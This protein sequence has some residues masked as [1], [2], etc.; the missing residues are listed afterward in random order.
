M[1]EKDPDL[2]DHTIGLS[3]LQW[4]YA[5]MLRIE[6][7]WTDQVQNQQRRIAAVLAVNGFLLAF[8]ATAGLQ[9][10]SDHLRGWYYYPF[11]LC[12]LLLSFALVFGV[13]TLFPQIPIAGREHGSDG[14][15]QRWIRDTF[16]KAAP[17]DIDALWLNAPAVWEGIS[18]EPSDA[19]FASTLE[20][21][22]KSLSRSMGNQSHTRAMTRRRKWMN[23]QIFFIVLSLVLLMVAVVGQAVH[24]L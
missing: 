3:N 7:H 14:S 6:G 4:T 13:I 2:T 20:E 1:N 12:L 18:G 11:Y 21:L 24:V 8:L 23:W 22:C 15:R 19:N 5:E 9:L 17:T 16:F 10:N